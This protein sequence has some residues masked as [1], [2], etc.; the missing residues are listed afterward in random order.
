MLNVRSLHVVFL[1]FALLVAQQFNAQM[2]EGSNLRVKKVVVSDSIVLDSLSL[3]PGSISLE[4]QI[5]FTADEPQALLRFESPFEYDSVTVTYRVLPLNLTQ[6]HYNKDT[7]LFSPNVTGAQNPFV[8]DQPPATGNAAGSFSRLSKTGS[9]S[10]GVSFGNNQN[11]GVNSNLNLQLAGKVTENISVKAAISDENIPVQPDGNTQ[12]LQDFDQV[13]IEVFDENSKLTAGDFMIKE[14]NSHFLQYNK[15]LRGGQIQT[16]FNLNEE[17]TKTNRVGLGAA[18]SRGKFSRNIIQGVEGNQGPYRLSGA[19]NENFIIILSGTEEVFID[20]RKLKRG[21]EYDYIIDYNQAEISF[22]AKQPVTKDKRI[23]VEFQYSSRAYARSLVEFHDHLDFG[24]LKLN[25]NAYS[26]QDSRNRPFQ[27]EL[28]EEQISILQNVGNNIDEAFAPAI[29]T[30]EYQ[31]NEIL[32]KL[33]RE[34]VPGSNIDSFFVFSNNPDSAV[35]QLQFSEVGQG[36]GNYNRARA[37]NNGAVYEFVPP[38]NGQSQGRFEP[39]VLLVTPKKR[40]MYTLGGTYDFNDETR[41]HFEVALSNTDENT[42]SDLGNENNIGYGLNWG[43]ETKQRLTKSKNPLTLHTGADIEYVDKN[44]NSVERFRDVE[45]DRQ[46]NIRDLEL[47]QTQILPGAFA[48][49]NKKELGTA[50]YGFKGFMGG[51]EYEAQ[52]HE[53]L[54]KGKYKGFDVDFNAFQTG[55]K[56]N[57]SKSNYYRHLTQITKDIKSVRIG[58][59]D[60]VENNRR[61]TPGTDSL[62]QTAYKWFEWETFVETADSNAN[63]Y[64]LGYT[65]RTDHAAPEG[66]FRR[67]TFGESYGFQFALDQNPRSRLSGKVTYRTLEVNDTVSYDGDPEENLIARLEYTF[68][69][70]KGALSST[71]FYE[72]G[73]GLEEEKDFVYV[74]VAPGQGVYQWIDYNDNGIQEQDEFEIARFPDQARFI[75]VSVRTNEFVKTYMNQFNQILNL[76]PARVWKGKEGLRGFFA[77][78][79]NQASFRL[80]RK[81]LEEDGFARLNPFYT[82]VDDEVLVTLNSSLRN[83]MFFN[84]NSR[85]FAVEWTYQNLGNKNLL[86]NGFESRTDQFN[87]ADLRVNITSQFQFNLIGKAGSKG[88]AVEFFNNRN[89]N[90]EYIQGNPKLTYQPSPAFALAVGYDYAVKENKRSEGEGEISTNQKVTGELRWNSL[91]KGSLNI[92]ANVIQ[93]DYEGDVNNALAFEMLEGLLP[94]ING[95]W[96]VLFQRTL[97]ENLQLNLNYNGRISQGSNVIHTGG[98]QVRAYF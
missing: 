26:E 90:I 89:F 23:I 96:D 82:T 42:Y 16:G 32:Y 71:S 50:R 72:I 31:E 70:F 53:A 24:K 13:Y 8:Y 9:I 27:Q 91:G 61:F 86:T 81:T 18:V 88:T 6:S 56:G 65:N 34:P 94:G 60:D 48:A 36:N 51:D 30:V 45:F 47:T 75:R 77:R 40:Q 92:R 55:T 37:G 63:Y 68:K 52:R 35:Y 28:N 58:Y 38:V 84:R 10:R 20:G 67:S 79:S 62:T 46:W 33:V 69:L 98:M 87:R 12:T 80:N 73:T 5:P 49:L 64:K 41:T 11:L 2:F 7:S 85:K 76:N 17:G 1:V 21:Q 66:E 25:F 43:I 93:I 59:R 78:F 83:T 14:P 3:V 74:E 4:P 54:V 22:T 97:G 44:F 57:K 19:E 95:T 15:R 29:N 39:I